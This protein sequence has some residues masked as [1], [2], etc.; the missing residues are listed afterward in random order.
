MRI[1]VD[2]KPVTK[3]Q[4]VVDGKPVTKEQ[5]KALSP[6]RIKSVTV[7]KKENT[8]YITLKKE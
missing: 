3:E 1:V 2:G 4:F 8:V 7:L 6:D 5:F